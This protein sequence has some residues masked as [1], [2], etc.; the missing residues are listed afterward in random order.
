MQESILLEQDKSGVA[1]V[2]FNRPQAMNA[3]TSAAMQQFAAVITQ[4]A[5]DKSVR[6][7]ILTGAGE[8]AFCSGGDLVE[9]RAQPTAVEGLAMVTLMGDALLQLERLPVPV[10]AA[11]NGYALGGGSEIALACDLRVVDESAR[12]GFV[13]IRMGL[14]P[15]WGAGQRLAR[16]VGG[17]KALEL[18]L[19]GEP[20]PA[21]T[22]LAL[23]LAN[24]QVAAGQAL[25]EARRWAGEIATQPA[26]V[27][28]AI[29]SLL[30]AHRT[31]PYEAALQHERSLFPDLWEAPA[32]VQAVE[33]FFE[34]HTER[35]GR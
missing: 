27:V 25:T 26:D 33:A 7:V 3:L 9:L 22:L 13:Q 2:T 34:R 14:T 19:A 29:K 17:P 20:L 5:T 4:L 8:R 31:Q 15:G 32:H 21:A 16:L 30:T 12:L 18:L 28:Q 35:K 11:I 23:G 24:R 1:V 6:A 10:I